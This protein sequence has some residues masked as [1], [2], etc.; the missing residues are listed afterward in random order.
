M[1]CRVLSPLA[2]TFALDLLCFI[3]AADAHLSIVVPGVVVVL[4]AEK[5][6]KTPVL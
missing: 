2:V 1:N 6:E 3:V 5:N 4:R